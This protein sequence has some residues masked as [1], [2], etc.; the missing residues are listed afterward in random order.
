VSRGKLSFVEIPQFSTLINLTKPK[1]LSS[2]SEINQRAS[3]RNLFRSSQF[4]SRELFNN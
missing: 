3:K 2:Q 4:N 1:F